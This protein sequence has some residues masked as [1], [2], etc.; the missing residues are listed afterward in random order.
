M[1]RGQGRT[2]LA[3]EQVLGLVRRD[4]RHGRKDVGAVGRR[5][6]D[7]VAVVDAAL[8]RLVVDVKVGQV[9]VK[10]DRARA[11]VPSEER[12]VRRAARR[13]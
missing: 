5:A 8:A 6:L 11:E 4:V 3:L 12:R 13:D 9:V 7:A 10:V 1:G 2:R